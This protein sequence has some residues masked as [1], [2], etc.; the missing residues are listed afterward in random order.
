MCPICSTRTF[1]RYFNATTIL[2]SFV[3]DFHFITTRTLKP[4]CWT[5]D[6]RRIN[7]RVLVLKY[8]SSIASGFVTSPCDHSR[9]FLPEKLT[10]S[11]HFQNYLHYQAYLSFFLNVSDS[12]LVLLLFVKNKIVF[13]VFTSAASSSAVSA[14][15]L[16]IIQLH[17]QNTY[18]ITSLCSS[19]SRNE[20]FC[21]S[22]SS[23]LISSS[24]ASSTFISRPSL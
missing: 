10:Q 18:L 3:V 4:F 22:I 17:D 24:C 13:N 1:E 21:L 20:F 14:S 9:I 19:T 8:G 16:L 5:K 15:S 11:A 7:H 12:T 6:F 2:F 23:S